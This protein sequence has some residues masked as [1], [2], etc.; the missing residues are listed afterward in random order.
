MRSCPIE[1]SPSAR[2]HPPVL[3]VHTKGP[4]FLASPIR[5]TGCRLCRS[6]QATAT[7]GRRLFRFV[8]TTSWLLSCRL[9]LLGRLSQASARAVNLFPKASKP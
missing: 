8:L 6:S 2:L 3:Q 7:S 9:L 4:G 1:R 5:T